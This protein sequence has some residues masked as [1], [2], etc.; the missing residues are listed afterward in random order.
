M[1]KHIVMQEPEKSI[2][3]PIIVSAVSPKPVM[4]ETPAEDK[5]VEE[6]PKIKEAVPESQIIPGI[7]KSKN[8]GPESPKPIEDDDKNHVEALLFAYGK[9]VD[10]DIISSLCNIDKRKIKKLLEQLKK[11]YET[12][13]SALMIFQQEHSWK[14]NVREKY[15]SLVRKIVA[16]TELARSVMETLAVIAWKSP[17]YQSEVVRIRGNKCYDHIDELEA[18]GYI[19]KEKKGRSYTLK[20]SEKFFNYFEIDHG[21]LKSVMDAVKMPEI[22]AE[23]VSKQTTLDDTPLISDDEKDKIHAIDV[24]KKIETEE[25]RTSHQQFLEDMEKRLIESAEKHRILTEDIPRPALSEPG[26]IQPPLISQNPEPEANI[27]I[28]QTINIPNDGNAPHETAQIGVEGAVPLNPEAEIAKPK[29]KSFTKKQ[30][31]KKFKDELLKV[32]EK[33][34]KK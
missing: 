22:N 32:R 31:E 15:L 33:M 27:S 30:L 7:P 17:I 10:E 34:E 13:N 5:M 25:E 21:N 20:T 29:H 24:R 4:L 8:T 9:Y 23:E 12:R 14:I 28:E 1:A 19:T 26:N 16:D 3:Q 11:D 2:E 6:L 18:S